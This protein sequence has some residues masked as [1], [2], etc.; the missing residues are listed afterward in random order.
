M[1]NGRYGSS[2]PTI[3]NC[4]FKPKMFWVLVDYAS[5]GSS[6]TNT[7]FSF[8]NVTQFR[9]D[10]SSLINTPRSGSLMFIDGMNGS[11]WMVYTGRTVTDHYY[12]DV[13]LTSTGISMYT[14]K[15]SSGTVSTDSVWMSS[16]QFNYSGTKFNY[17][18][19]G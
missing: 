1:G 12:L 9:N 14:R 2:N 18:A 5:V 7:V 16:I 19:L 15:S 4:G 11:D 17:I 10:Y 8:T 13:N 3:I 6:S